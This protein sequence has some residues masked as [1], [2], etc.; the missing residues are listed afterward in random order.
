MR[1]KT[2][3]FGLAMGILHSYP[4]HRRQTNGAFLVPEWPDFQTHPGRF[5]F[6]DGDFLPCHLKRMA[7]QK[8]TL[9]LGGYINQ[10]H[11]KKSA[12]VKLGLGHLSPNGGVNILKRY[13][14]CHHR[15]MKGLFFKHQSSGCWPAVFRQ[16]LP[17][18]KGTN[19]F[20]L[21][22]ET[23]VLWWRD[24]KRMVYVS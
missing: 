9:L 19:T 24:P 12:K 7:S 15:V 10:P 1:N 20:L 22:I 2:H 13:L 16:Q 6:G 11:L 3:P 4:Q 17:N 21:S 18:E 5:G 8:R 23:L 14:S